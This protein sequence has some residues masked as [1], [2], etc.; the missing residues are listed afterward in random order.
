MDLTT[1]LRAPCLICEIHKSGISKAQSEK[2]RTCEERVLY[3]LQIRE[4]Y[5]LNY[6]YDGET[7]E[8][9]TIGE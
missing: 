3:D 5:L 1:K 2:C 6:N 4:P 9:D 8:I 7:N